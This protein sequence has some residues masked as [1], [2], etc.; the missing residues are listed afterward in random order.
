M[1]RCNSDRIASF[2]LENI[3]KDKLMLYIIFFIM[4]PAD[5]Q[6]KKLSF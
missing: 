4:Y 3:E 1:K 5:L 6:K 2:F